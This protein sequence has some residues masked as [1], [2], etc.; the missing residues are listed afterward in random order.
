M[1]FTSY[2]RPLNWHHYVSLFE[3]MSIEEFISHIKIYRDKQ[4]KGKKYHLREIDKLAKSCSPMMI[5][6]TPVGRMFFKGAPIL[7]RSGAY[8]PIHQNKT[9]SRCRL[10][11]EGYPALITRRIIGKIPYKSDIKS[12]QT[13]AQKNTRAEIMHH[14]LRYHNL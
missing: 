12:K 10:I 5:D 7:K 1:Y 9:D 2:P 3:N 8:I 4:P 6:Y 13:S 14:I 11:V